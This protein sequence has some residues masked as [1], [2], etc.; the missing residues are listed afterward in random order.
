MEEAV[1]VVAVSSV[2]GGRRKTWSGKES[3]SSNRGIGKIQSPWPEGSQV[4]RGRNTR[5]NLRT[6]DGQDTRAETRGTIQGRNESRSGKQSGK[7]RWRERHGA[8]TIWQRVS[9]VRLL[10]CWLDGR[11]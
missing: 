3:G 5:R 4:F 2:V 7:Q 1:C 9:G 11:W 8:V 6:K 10:I